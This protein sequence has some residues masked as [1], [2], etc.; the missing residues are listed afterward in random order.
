MIAPNPLGW[1][2]ILAPVAPAP[3]AAPSRF[4]QRYGEA[5]AA[6]DGADT[7][8]AQRISEVCGGR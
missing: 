2:G 5:S 7:G 8:L 6:K 1:P 3:P 4:V